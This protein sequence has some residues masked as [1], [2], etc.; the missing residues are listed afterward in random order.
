MDF[1]I[2]FTEIIAINTFLVLPS[3]PMHSRFYSPQ[4]YRG[5]GLSSEI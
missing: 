4:F 2:F 1:N 5:D 3:S